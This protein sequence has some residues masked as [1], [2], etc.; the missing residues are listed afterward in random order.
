MAKEFNNIKVL[1][2]VPHDQFRDEEYFETRKALEKEGFKVVVASSHSSTAHGRFGAKVQPDIVISKINIS[3]YEA[4]IFIGGPGV[5]EY[6][7]EFEVLSI[8]RASF[9]KRI[10]LGAICSAPVILANAGILTGRRVTAFGSRKELIEASGAYYIDKSVVL[11]GEII[12]A[13]GPED[14]KNFGEA[15]VKAIKWR[16]DRKGYLL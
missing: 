14:A 13:K 6:F 3:D 16:R 4:I 1:I 7:D 5:E 11:D 8:V 9:Q 2:I 15:I 10:L 12:T